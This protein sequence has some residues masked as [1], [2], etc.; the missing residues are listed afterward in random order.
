MDYSERE[1]MVFKGLISLI[2]DGNN[3]YTITVSDIA[4]S[5]NMGKGSLY[6][7][8]SSKKEIISQALLY[9]IEL[10]IES[11]CNRIDSKEKFK[12][13]FYE[14]LSIITESL[15]DNASMI[16]VFLSISGIREF[17]KDFLDEDCSMKYFLDTVN[18]IMAHLL[19]V[20]YNEGVIDKKGD[21][22]YQ[23]MAIRGSLSGFSYYLNKKDVYKEVSIDV[24]MDTAYTILLK[25]LN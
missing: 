24:A 17:Y 12:E 19:E 21:K 4:E 10:E 11:A 9:F 13:K 3:P 14:L 2:K 25:T 5:A 20:G 1:I 16:N 6:D 7:Y 22:F 8:F 15:E 23:M 18:S